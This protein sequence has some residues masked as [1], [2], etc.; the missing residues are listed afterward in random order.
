MEDKYK[1][2]R[3]TVASDDLVHI[4]K[5]LAKEAVIRRL[6]LLRNECATSEGVFATS[7]KSMLDSVIETIRR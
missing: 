1:T 7:V 3:Q 6:M 4:H 5:D 2:C